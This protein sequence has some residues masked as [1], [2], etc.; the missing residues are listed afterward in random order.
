MGRGKKWRR[1]ED[2]SL[3]TAYAAVASSGVKDGP[4]FWDVV[5]SRVQSARSVRA[6]R[7][8]WVLMSHEVKVF[9]QY[10]NRIEAQGASEE[11]AA[12]ERAM[13]NFRETKGR[14]FEFISCWDIVRKCH[15]TRR[16]GG[17]A[18][19]TEEEVEEG[20]ES[21]ASTAQ[22]AAADTAE[23]A[24]YEVQTPIGA[25]V[26][27]EKEERTKAGTK[28]KR[29]ASPRTT[30]PA[31]DDLMFVQQQLVS[32]MRR[33]NDLQEDELALKLFGEGRESNESQHFFKLLKR[34]KLLLLEKEVEELEIAQQRLRQRRC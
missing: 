15:E 16:G 11:V 19:E 34:K 33:K 14:D 10:L 12:V 27:D 29:S 18:E 28:T 17:E 2:V 25:A 30:L 4:F 9:V 24:E 1:D 31:T 32:E 8:R 22:I 5:R 6:L 26:A 20:D 13:S 3:A 7:N 23:V 21:G